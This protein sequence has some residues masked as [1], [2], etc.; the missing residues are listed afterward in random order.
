MAL[1]DEGYKSSSENF[2]IPTT[3]RRTLK[4]HHVSSVEN[5]SFDPTA[6]TPHST[7]DLQLKPVHGRLTYSS[8]DDADTSEDEV[9]PSYSR[10][11]VQYHRSDLQAPDSRHNLNIHV[12]LQEEEDEEEDFQTIPLNNEHWTTEEI[13]D[14][15]LCIH[16]HSLPHILALYPCPY[17]NYQILS[18]VET[19]DL[20]DIS[21][22]EDI[23]ITSVMKTYLDLKLL[24][25]ERTLVCSEH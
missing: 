15:P 9:P 18:Y 19:M 25:A 20:S 22:F 3:L 5:A 4:I 23:M 8:S 13:P 2:N 7:R 21:N 1:E 11:Q 10:S 17:M 12:H 16:K 24:H 6:V 14:R